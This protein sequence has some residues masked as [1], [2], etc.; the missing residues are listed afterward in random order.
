MDR[1]AFIEKFSAQLKEWNEEIGKLE[2]KARKAG[3]KSGE[4]YEKQIEDLKKRRTKAENK[5]EDIR[6]ASENAWEELKSG[7]EK[8]FN[9][10]KESAQAARSKF[11]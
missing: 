4:Y 10:I 9:D 3:E 7:T 8:A 11:K 1:E 2:A 5:L 6:N